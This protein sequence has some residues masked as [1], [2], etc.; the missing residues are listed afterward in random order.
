MNIDPD[1]SPAYYINAFWAFLVNI[2]GVNDFSTFFSCKFEPIAQVFEKIGLYGF[3]RFDFNRDQPG[4]L[5]NDQVNFASRFISL[6]CIIHAF[7][8]G[9]MRGVE[10]RRHSILFQGFRNEADGLK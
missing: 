9:Q 4:R 8:S 6:T 10:S 7:N 2:A 5:I 3:A 1:I